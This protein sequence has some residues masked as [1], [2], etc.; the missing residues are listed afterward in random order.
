MAWIIA[1]I[2]IVY[3]LGGAVVHGYCTKTD[4]YIHDADLTMI[5]IFWPIV[6]IAFLIVNIMKLMSGFGEWIASLFGGDKK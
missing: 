4:P 6:L 5:I 1:A 3:I 2:I